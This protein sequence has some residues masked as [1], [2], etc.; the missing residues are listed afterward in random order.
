MHV[1]LP[2]QLPHAKCTQPIRLRKRKV[3]HMTQVIVY[4]RDECEPCKK[5]KEKLHEA[6]IPFEEVDITKLS[7]DER[8]VVID[9]ILKVS[10]LET[11]TVPAV[12]VLGRRDPAWISNHGSCDVSEM[13]EEIRFAVS[14]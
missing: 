13:L 2:N 1:F 4:G 5:L 7:G 10:R 11:A 14:E 9:N 3:S 12:K 6:N 8:Q